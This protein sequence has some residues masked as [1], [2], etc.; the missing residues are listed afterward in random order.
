MTPPPAKSAPLPSVRVERSRDT[1]SSAAE[2]W[3]RRRSAKPL[4]FARGER[5]DFGARCGCFDRPVLS[6]VEGLSP[7]GVVFQELLA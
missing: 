4:D 7:N 6:L 1:F 5:M 2:K 3:P